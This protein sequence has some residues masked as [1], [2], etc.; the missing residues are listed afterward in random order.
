[1]VGMSSHRAV[2][3]FTPREW[4][5][6]EAAAIIRAH[7]EGQSNRAIARTFEVDAV[8]PQPSVP[9]GALAARGPPDSHPTARQRVA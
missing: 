9:L 5:P 7:V 4:T 8:E 2:S 1:M 3:K 6:E